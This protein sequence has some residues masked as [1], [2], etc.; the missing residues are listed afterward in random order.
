[1]LN[2]IDEQDIEY[3]HTMT[4]FLSLEETRQMPKIHA[5]FHKIC[6]TATFDVEYEILEGWCP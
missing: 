3:G 1:M 5:T 2:E 6:P 4:W